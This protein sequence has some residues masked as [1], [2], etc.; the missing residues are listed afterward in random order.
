[1]TSQEFLN[2]NNE[3]SAIAYMAGQGVPLE[4]I[5][6]SIHSVQMRVAREYADNLTEEK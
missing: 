4:T 1:M 2:L 5:R 6:H 3:L